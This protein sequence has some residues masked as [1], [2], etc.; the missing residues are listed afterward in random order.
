M[1][2]ILI[3][4]ALIAASCA[5]ITPQ[6]AEAQEQP[7]IAGC[8]AAA[9]GREALERCK[10]I[11]VAACRR[12][13][14]NL[15]STM[16]LVLCNDREATEWQGILEAQIARVSE[17]QSNRAEELAAAQAAW[18]AWRDAE[19]AFHRADAEGGS[20]EQVVQVAC[21]LDLTA[22][23]VIAFT[24]LERQGGSLY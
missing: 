19:C 17:R 2:R 4:L 8:V 14:E 24:T 7:T 18:E 11:V 1:G 5:P 9:Q 12:E 16:G 3:A 22:N 15:D 20:G 23:R 10:G 6:L 13:P 21:I